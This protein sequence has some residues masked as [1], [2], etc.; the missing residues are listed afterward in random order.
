MFIVK[1]L[2]IWLS[3]Q[4]VCIKLVINYSLHFNVYNGV[5]QWEILSP[6]VFNIYIDGLTV[7][8]N[9]SNGRGRIG[10]IFL[11]HSC[12]ANDKCLNPFESI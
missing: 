4:K 6:N 2:A 10:S 1:I 8:P 11:N 12:Y 3:D 9:G 5:K 7:S